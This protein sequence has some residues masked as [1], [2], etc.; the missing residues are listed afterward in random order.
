MKD[1]VTALSLMF[2]IEGAMYALFPLGMKNLL[3]RV[4]GMDASTLRMMGIGMAL[5]GF[6]FV[7]ALRGF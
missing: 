1:L 2:V 3:E 4:Q 7:G 6:I 5:M